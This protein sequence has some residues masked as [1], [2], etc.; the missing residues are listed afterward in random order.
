MREFNTAGKEFEKVFFTVNK[1]EEEYKNA[2][3]KL[4]E[5]GKGFMRLTDFIVQE[6]VYSESENE[7]M[8]K[9]RDLIKRIDKRDLYAVVK[10]I[11]VSELPDEYFV[12]GIRFFLTSV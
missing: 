11:R 8:K 6:I 9:A 3:E 5:T 7:H 12:V 1:D 2:A 10:Q 4:K